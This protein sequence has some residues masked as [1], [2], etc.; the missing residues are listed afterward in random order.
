M[1]LKKLQK[2]A[3]SKNKKELRC[4][5]D[6]LAMITAHSMCSMEVATAM[7]QCKLIIIINANSGNIY[8]DAMNREMVLN[9]Y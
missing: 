2:S 5:C 8:L 9:T 1:L 4:R 6:E 7:R 3:K